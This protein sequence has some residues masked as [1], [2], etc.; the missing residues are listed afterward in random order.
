MLLTRVR[1]LLTLMFALAAV[2]SAH[3]AD[4]PLW[5]RFE[6]VIENGRTYANPFRDVELD[7]VFA[8]PSGRA[9]KTDLDYDLVLQLCYGQMQRQKKQRDRIGSRALLVAGFNAGW[10]YRGEYFDYL[11]EHSDHLIFNNH[12][13]WEKRGRPPN[14]SAISNGVDLDVFR[15][16]T[17][18]EE[19][20][21]LVIWT[22]S[23]YHRKNG[24]RYR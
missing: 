17:P 14:T 2:C 11:R 20:K 21:P 6:T 23:E 10:G 18:I 9:V 22:G 5:G 4:I 12:E 3:A 19:R 13:N 8:S 1:C 15:V 24:N 7:A 16:T